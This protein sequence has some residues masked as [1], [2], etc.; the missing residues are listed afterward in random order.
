MSDYD[1]TQNRNASNYSVQP[2]VSVDYPKPST[3]M[4]P[5]DHPATNMPTATQHHWGTVASTSDAA[6]RGAKKSPLQ[7]GMPVTPE[8]DL[9]YGAYD[10]Q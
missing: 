6:T 5:A 10:G 9:P 4:N 1:M 8:G 7:E 3:P 2:G